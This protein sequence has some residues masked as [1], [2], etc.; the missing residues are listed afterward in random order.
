MTTVHLNPPGNIKPE[1]E[2]TKDQINPD[3]DSAGFSRG[4]IFSSCYLNE[5]HFS[6]FFREVLSGIPLR[7][8]KE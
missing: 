5:T 1:Q 4:G 8:L 3:F 6:G 2:D 7:G